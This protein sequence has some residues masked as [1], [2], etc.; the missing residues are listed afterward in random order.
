M[1]AARLPAEEARPTEAGDFPA[2]A[3]LPEEA[4]VTGSETR[5]TCGAPVLKARVC[6]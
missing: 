4:A 5:E 1:E 2:E 3:M 6:M